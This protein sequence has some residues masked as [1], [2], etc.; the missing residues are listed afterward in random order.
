MM[1]SLSTDEEVKMFK[2]LIALRIKYW[3]LKSGCGVVTSFDTGQVTE[4]NAIH[5]QLLTYSPYRLISDPG[6]VYTC[7]IDLEAGKNVILCCLSKRAEGLELFTPELDGYCQRLK[8]R[9]QRLSVRKY[10]TCTVRCLPLL[11][12]VVLYDR[13]QRVVTLSLITTR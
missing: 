4:Q 1:S 6:Q 12:H 9:F 8:E 2:I 5:F 10:C 13:Y 3:T 11:V 7:L